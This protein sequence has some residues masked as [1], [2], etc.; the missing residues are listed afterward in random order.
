MYFFIPNSERSRL[1]KNVL[2]VPGALQN[3]TDKSFWLTVES[4][5]VYCVLASVKSDSRFL[6]LAQ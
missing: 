2:M 4:K 6:M 1:I 5:I 3:K